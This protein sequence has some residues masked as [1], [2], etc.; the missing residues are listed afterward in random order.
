MPSTPRRR[1][2]TVLFFDIVNSTA[3]ASELGDDRWREFLALF[4]RTVQR[5]LKRGGGREQDPAGD[6]CLVVFTQPAQ[7]LR[8]AAALIVDAQGLGVDIR[9]GVHT[10]ECEV[11]DGKLCGV[12]VHIGARVMALAGPAEVLATATVRDLTTG[13]GVRFEPYGHAT[14]KGVDGDWGLFRA[15]VVGEAPL[16]PALSAAE[17]LSRRAALELGPRGPRRSRTALIAAAALGALAMAV[18]TPLLTFGSTDSKRRQRRALPISLVRINPVSDKVIGLVR[19]RYGGLSNLQAD[20]GTLWQAERRVIVVERD[21]R[22]GRVR[23]R[24]KVS[25]E[26]IYVQAGFGSV[27]VLREDNFVA[28][29]DRID[30]LSGRRVTINLPSKVSVSPALSALSVGA[31]RVW[32]LDDAGDV[33]AIDPA[34]NRPSVPIP[35]GVVADWLQAFG[36]YVWLTATYPQRELVRLD[37]RRRRTRRYPLPEHPWIL[38]PSGKEFWLGDEVDGTLSLFDPKSGRTDAPFGLAGSPDLSGITS[39]FGRLW[40]AAGKQVDWIY[41]ERWQG[42]IRMPGGVCA[43]DVAVDTPTNTVWV[44]TGR[45]PDPASQLAGC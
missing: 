9:C 18:I 22:T 11:V 7:A 12:A 2:A 43:A 19:D 39:G 30:G 37:P 28:K 25:P 17:T 35:T 32:V 40:I 8:T 31:G 1:L 44:S 29:V 45:N 14:L 33:T 26:A 21:A 5:Q 24:I 4:W 16:P 10:G 41:N 34:T 23:R 36:P 20:N 38:I 27:W 3:F 42:S 13:S 6:G 15:T